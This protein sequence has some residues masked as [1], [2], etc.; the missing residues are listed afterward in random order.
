M[1]LG[2]SRIRWRPTSSETWR[3][4]SKSMVRWIGTNTCRPVLPEVFTIGSSAMRVQQ[5]A[6]PERD[7]L[8]LLEGDGVELRLGALRLLARVDVRVDVEQ[9]VVGVVED[10]AP[11]AT[12]AR[13]RSRCLRSRSRGPGRARECQTWNSSVPDC[14]SHSSVGRLLHSRYSCCSSLWL[15]EHGDRLDEIGPRLL[16]VL[17]EE[18][19]AADA[20]GHADHRERPVGEVRQHV[21]RHLREVAQQVALGERGLPQRRV[22]RPVDAVE[23]GELDRVRARRRA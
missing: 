13:S 22:G 2:C 3:A 5:L 9:H 4:A 6:Q 8:A 17:L 19:L 23:V 15:G 14:A 12:R 7:F 10:R 21:R 18:A 11:R 16:P 20:V 1:S